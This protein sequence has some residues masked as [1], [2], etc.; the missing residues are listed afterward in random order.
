MQIRTRTRNGRSGENL[1]GNGDNGLP[2]LVTHAILGED[3]IDARCLP[4]ERC[5]KRSSRRC[6]AVEGWLPLHVIWIGPCFPQSTGFRLQNVDSPSGYNVN[7]PAASLMLRRILRLLYELCVAAGAMLAL[8]AATATFVPSRWDTLVWLPNCCSPLHWDQILERIRLE[9][10][11]KYWQ[12][13][14]VHVG[15]VMARPRDHR[16]SVSRGIITSRALSREKWDFVCFSNFYW[17]DLK[18]GRKCFTMD[19]ERILAVAR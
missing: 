12:S 18:R 14:G 17:I 1:V 15:F 2:Y 7:E 10:P 6:C 5:W 3:A 8:I 19:M 4:V 13:C 9:G 16:P 11:K